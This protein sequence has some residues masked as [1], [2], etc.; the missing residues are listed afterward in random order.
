MRY[1]TNKRLISGHTPGVTREYMYFTCQITHTK[2]ENIMFNLHM[3]VR[4]IAILMSDLMAKV[5]H[6]DWNLVSR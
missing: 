4:S 6:V 2:K 1:C 3:N 5:L